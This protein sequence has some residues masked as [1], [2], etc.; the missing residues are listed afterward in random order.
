[1]NDLTVR[2]C[3]LEALSGSDAQGLIIITSYIAIYGLICANINANMN[4]GHRSCEET[5]MRSRS[6]V[7]V[8]DLFAKGTFGARNRKVMDCHKRP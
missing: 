6:R 1:M 3:V 8:L 7:S 2:R 5:H 4:T